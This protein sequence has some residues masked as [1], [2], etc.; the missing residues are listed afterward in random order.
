M[1]HSRTHIIAGTVADATGVKGSPGAILIENGEI[2]AAGAVTEIGECPGA[3]RLELPDSVV[4]P[5][6]VNAHA[7]LDLTHIGPLPHGNDFAAWLDRILDERRAVSDDGIRQSV[8][9]GASLSIE[10]GTVLVG[11]ISGA[12]SLEPIHALRESALAGVS[13]LE[14]FGIG[15]NQSRAAERLREIVSGIALEEGGVRLGVSPHAPYTC[16]IELYEAAIRV[17][18]PIATHLAESLEELQF[19]ATGDGAFANLLKKIGVWDQSI[20]GHSCHPVK[21]LGD[22]FA[23]VPL[24]AAHLNYVDDDCI[25]QMAQMPITVAYCPRASAYFGHPHQEHA[26][27]RYRDM[28][29]AGINVALGTDSIVCLDT[30]DRISVLDDMRF[31]HRRDGT[32]PTTLLQMATI[33]GAKGLGFDQRLVTFDPGPIAGIVAVRGESLKAALENDEPPVRLSLNAELSA[34]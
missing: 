22:Q 18:L 13:Y 28:L 3:D 9:K 24:I 31:L 5:G 10:G 20:A 30:A 14:V 34:T 33:N 32:D 11:D 2:V 8:L 15:E 7:H 23:H 12:W 21:L 26:P 27:H 16:G 29:S 1:K 17:G 25:E 4:L 19:T 6:L